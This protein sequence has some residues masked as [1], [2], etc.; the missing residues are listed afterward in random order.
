MTR[1]LRADELL[2][3]AALSQAWPANAFAVWLLDQTDGGDTAALPIGA[4]D[5]RLT[6]LRRATFG[7]RLDLA[8]DCPACGAAL[9]VTLSTDALPGEDIPPPRAHVAIG[10]A[11]FAIRP[12]TTLD[13]EEAAAEP[14]LAAVRARL[15]WA[16]LDPIDAPL[17]LALTPKE[18]EAIADALAMLD[19]AA[20]P[21]V[22]LNCPRCETAWDAPVD[23]A[24]LIAADIAGAAGALLDEV[25][26]LALAYHWSEAAI[27]ALPPARRHAYLARVRG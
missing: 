6:A 5:R 18:I 17:P 4:R 11:A 1:A 13:L 3:A 14:D 22:A 23:I 25:H 27:L 7:D 24:R 26:D 2:D 19:P 21:Y 9:D 12:L 16:A 10:G 8:A 15:A 20:D